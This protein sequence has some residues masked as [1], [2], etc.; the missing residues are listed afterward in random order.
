[1]GPVT[2]VALVDRTPNRERTA[3][4][5]ADVARMIVDAVDPPVFD[6]ATPVG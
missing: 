5:I 3:A 1:M 6:D 2:V 4:V